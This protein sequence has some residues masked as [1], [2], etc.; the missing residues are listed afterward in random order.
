VVPVVFTYVDDALAWLRRRFSRA[1][2]AA[3]P[4]APHGAGAE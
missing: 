2:P 1:K 3:M 4:S